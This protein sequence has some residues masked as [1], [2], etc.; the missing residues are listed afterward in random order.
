MLCA[1]VGGIV[2]GLHRSK[3]RVSPRT[4]GAA[5]ATVHRMWPFFRRGSAESDGVYDAFVAETVGARP[6]RDAAYKALSTLLFPDF[7]R[8]LYVSHGCVMHLF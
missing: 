8:V 3:L 1:D 4:S 5:S 6:E 2:P 7:D